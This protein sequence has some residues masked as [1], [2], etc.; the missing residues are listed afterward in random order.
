MGSTKDSV[1]LSKEVILFL[2]PNDIPEDYESRITNKYPGIQVRWYNT[3][4]PDGPHTKPEEIVPKELH[5]PHYFTRVM[6]IVE[7]N[8]DRLSRG[9][10]LINSIDKKLNY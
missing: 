6:D 3:L 10:K 2:L 9:E 7:R 8:L 4:G 1:D 5:T